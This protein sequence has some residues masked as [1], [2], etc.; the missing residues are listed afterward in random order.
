L[1]IFFTKRPFTGQ[2]RAIFADH[3]NAEGLY[4]PESSALTDENLK[5]FRK[6]LKRIEK[7]NRKGGGWFKPRPTIGSDG[8]TKVRRGAWVPWKFLFMLAGGFLAFKVF[9]LINLGENVYHQKLS[10]VDDGSVVGEIGVRLMELDQVT[11]RMR[12]VVVP[13]VDNIFV[14]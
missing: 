3:T 9:L 14:N 1:P 5:E 8:L 12:D 6:R 11:L 13:I 4:H 2:K 10:V 7:K